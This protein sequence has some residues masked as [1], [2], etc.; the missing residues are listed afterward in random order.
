MRQ[1]FQKELEWYE[2]QVPNPVQASRIGNIKSQVQDQV[3][4][5]VRA[6]ELSNE[7]LGKKKLAVGL[8][9]VESQ[10]FPEMAPI[11][12]RIGELVAAE[13]AAAAR[14]QAAQN[15]DVIPARALW[16]GS[17]GGGA[18]G[19]YFGGATGGIQGAALGAA[20]PYA[21]GNPTIGGA[22]ASALYRGGRA[23]GSLGQVPSALG[24][25][26]ESLRREAEASLLANGST[27]KP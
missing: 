13:E 23:L 25:S 22:G 5:G 15:L 3:S 16:G 10:A 2:S 20:I 21:L 6:K 9:R 24:V 7:T 17:L 1:A 11:N 26:A 19:G 4:Y 18:L 8:R 27:E 12:K 14:A